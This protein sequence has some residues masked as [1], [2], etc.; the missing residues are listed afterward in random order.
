MVRKL[1][2]CIRYKKSKRQ[3]NKKKISI[4]VRR[5]PEYN[6]EDGFI[7]KTFKVVDNSSQNIIQYFGECLNFIKGD[8]KV[9]VHCISGSSRSASIVIAYIMWTKKMTYEDA[10]KFVSDKRKCVNPK[11]GFTE[12]LKLFEKLLKENEYNIDKINF[13]DIK[14]ESI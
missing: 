4:S 13:K 8:E 10:F 3:K 5:I 14:L 7:H 12:Q 11:K 1:F 9:L 2:F 6:N